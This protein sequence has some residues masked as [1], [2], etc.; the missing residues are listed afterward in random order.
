MLMEATLLATSPQ[1]RFRAYSKPLAAN[2]LQIQIETV[3]GA[4]SDWVTWQA[5]IAL[6]QSN[7]EFRTLLTAAL[8]RCPYTAFFWETPPIMATT[9]MKPW[10][11]VVVDAPAL[12]KGQADPQPFARYIG[13]GQGTNTVTTFPNL[14][15]DAQLVVPCC[16]GDLDTY[17]HLGTFLRQG[18]KPQINALWQRVGQSIQAV[19]GDRRIEPLWVSTSGMGVYWLHIRLD[20]QP[21][22]YTHAPYRQAA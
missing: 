1:G 18:L 11:C 8:I 20:S 13:P 4:V 15:G 5:A 22:Y 19:L 7:N 16:N 17:T 3:D 21:K 9:L 14:Q 6:L 12:V 10:E 2:T